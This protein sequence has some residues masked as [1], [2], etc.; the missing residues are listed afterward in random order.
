MV[1]RSDK[2]RRRGL[3]SRARTVRCILLCKFPGRAYSR[4]WRRNGEMSVGKK[5]D[6]KPGAGGLTACLNAASSAS[7][8][9]T[10]GSNSQTAVSD[11]RKGRKPAPGRPWTDRSCPLSPGNGALGLKTRLLSGHSGSVTGRPP[12][13]RCRPRQSRGLL[14]W[15]WGSILRRPDDRL[16]A[17]YAD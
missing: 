3:R 2:R 5:G 15:P 13:A 9:P 11:S 7:F 8:G 14:R 4:C 12:R 17:G 1:T 10:W 6:G 16:A